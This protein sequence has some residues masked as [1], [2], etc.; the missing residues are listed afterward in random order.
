MHGIVYLIHMCMSQY[1]IIKWLRY[2]ILKHLLLGIGMSFWDKYIHMM[3]PL[4]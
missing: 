4:F 2:I 3:E 1:T